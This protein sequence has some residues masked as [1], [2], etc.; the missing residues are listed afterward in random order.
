MPIFSNL[1]NTL[2]M[3]NVLPLGAE[4]K[5]QKLVEE[6]LSEVLD[7]KFIASEYMTTSGGRIDTLAID[8]DGAPVI[9][10]Y[11]RNQNDNVINQALSYL[12]WLKAQRPE[13][14]KML[15]HDRFGKEEADKIR[16]DW[17]NPRVICIAESF[18]KFDTDTVEVVPLRIDL[19]KYRYYESGLFSLDLVNIRE[20]SCRGNVPHPVQDQFQSSITEV[21]KEQGKASHVIR[22]IFDELRE[23]IMRMDEYIIEKPGKRTISY[24][25]TKKFAEI[26][27]SKDRLVISLRGIEYLDPKNLV[28]KIGA[29]YVITLNRR[30]TIYELSDIDYVLG[31]VEQSYQNVL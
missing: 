3:L 9:I 8:N 6:N 30:I 18:N 19:F 12:K 27:I 7:M 5:L 11:K 2:K 29:G 23:K 13:F 15:I 31:I 4:R 14:F 20:E 21:M 16:L 28:E 25:L 17:K 26:Q 22:I 1:N 24:A 10:E